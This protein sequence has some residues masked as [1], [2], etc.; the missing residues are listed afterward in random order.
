MDN[1]NCYFDDRVKRPV[2]QA[3]IDFAA[4]ISTLDIEKPSLVKLTDLLKQIVFFLRLKDNPPA[5]N[6]T[7][8]LTQNEMANLDNDS[9]TELDSENEDSSI[10]KPSTTRNNTQ[11]RKEEINRDGNSNKTSKRKT[12]KPNKLKTVI[13]NTEPIDKQNIDTPPH[14]PSEPSSSS[15]HTDLIEDTC[16]PQNANKNDTEISSIEATTLCQV[17]EQYKQT[18]SQPEFQGEE[19]HDQSE[20][21]SSEPLPPT[22]DI[23]ADTNTDNNTG[24]TF[25]QPRKTTCR[26]PIYIDDDKINWKYVNQQ[27]ALNKIEG[28]T[29]TH[30]GKNKFQIK[31]TSDEQHRHITKLLTLNNIAYYSFVLPSDK[32]V[33]VIIRSLPVDTDIDDLKDALLV[34]S[35][36]V[37]S[38]SQLTR[39]RDGNV[40]KLPLFLVTL[41]RTDKGR[42]IHNLKCI[43]NLKIT[44]ESYKGRGGVTMCHNCQQYFHSQIGCRKPSRCV[45]CA[46]NHH[47]KQCTHVGDPKCANCGDKHTANWIGCPMRP[48]EPANRGNPRP[49]NNTQTIPQVNNTQGRVYT[50]ST[51]TDTTNA[52]HKPPNITNVIRQD[53]SSFQT[54]NQEL[55]IP[56]IDKLEENNTKNEAKILHEELSGLVKWIKESGLIDLLR[57][58]KNSQP[59]KPTFNNNHVQ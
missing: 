5:E 17:S 43:M 16:I 11:F 59:N 15:A 55:H 37:E 3:F 45:K 18:Q 12:H 31:A 24:A 58:F 50:N 13:I 39:R 6:K 46:G 42:D 2:D 34:N 54:V 49:S 21:S 20:M 41:S 25:Q 28:F 26:T 56:Q 23:A 8:F 57:E 14:D 52:W 53:S 38:V 40:T 4:T 48:S 1:F 51:I 47:T 44:V 10:N 33:K 30:K 27:L 29:A 36:P 9:T 7:L 22:Q 35:F 32:K 19:L